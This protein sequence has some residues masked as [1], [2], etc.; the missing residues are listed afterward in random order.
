[1]GFG[2]RVYKV[3]DPR[4]DV[5]SQAAARLYGSSGQN[6]GNRELY[7][8][9]RHVEATAIRLLEEFKPGRN[10]QTNVEFYTALVLHGLQLGTDL[11]TPTFAVGRVP[12][13]IAHCFEQQQRGRL[14][15]P[16]SLYDGPRDREWVAL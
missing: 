5:L 15:R 1:M 11:F 14:I 4:A 16:T 10:L 12:G 7:E 13:W 8:L 9:A 3:R 2:H 6:N